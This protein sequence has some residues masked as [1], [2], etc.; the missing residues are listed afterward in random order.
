MWIGQESKSKDGLQ[1]SSK[2]QLLDENFKTAFLKRVW[3]QSAKTD[4][5]E[6]RE[7]KSPSWKVGWENLHK[8][9]WNT[10]LKNMLKRR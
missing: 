1:K 6:L 9:P 10:T 4:T 7:G 2:Q 8:Q 3:K 5:V